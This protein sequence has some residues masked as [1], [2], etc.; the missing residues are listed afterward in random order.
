MLHIDTQ[1]TQPPRRSEREAAKHGGG[2]EVVEDV[3]RKGVVRP[4]AGPQDMNAICFMAQVN[5]K[6]G[7]P[8][9][10]LV[11]TG[12]E[13]PFVMDV[14]CARGLACMRDAVL[15]ADDSRRAPAMVMELSEMSRDRRVQSSRRTAANASAPQ[16]PISLHA[17]SSS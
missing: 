9:N 14:P 6:A 2:T 1:P 8:L 17:R 5:R 16:S 12:N 13:A 11:H 10:G 3:P 15:A 7:L 4:P